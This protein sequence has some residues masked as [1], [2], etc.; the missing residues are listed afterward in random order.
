MFVPLLDC[1]IVEQCALIQFLMSVGV[2]SST[3][4][5]QK[6]VQYRENYIMQRN[7]Y[8][9]VESFQSGWTSVVDKDCSGHMTTSWEA[10]SVV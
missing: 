3:I 10:D 8:Q 4:H 5:R 6:L 9:W 2:K 7:V 1:T